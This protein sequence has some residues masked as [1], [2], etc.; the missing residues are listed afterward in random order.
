MRLLAAAFCLLALPAAA[1]EFRAVGEN[2]AVLYDAPSRQA[3]PLF[4][5]T[6]HYPLE[7]LVELEAWVKVRDHTGA[8]SW[9]EKRLLTDKR[10]VVVTATSAEAHQRPEDGAPVAFIAAQN[11]ALEL[12]E[13]AQ[14]GAQDGSQSEW[15]HVRH[16]DGADGFLR[17]TAC[18]GD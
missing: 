5:V 6:R 9:V 8:I 16:A 17:A 15:L 1:G 12:L 2:A 4:V 18:W 11:V 7:L 10:M 14:K 3:T 13:P